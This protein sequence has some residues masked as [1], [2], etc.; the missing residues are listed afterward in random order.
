MPGSSSGLE[1]TGRGV[2]HL[3]CGTPPM[4]TGFGAVMLGVRPVSTGRL[5]REVTRTTNT[6]LVGLTPPARPLLE[7]FDRRA[8][9]GVD[10][11]IVVQLRDLE[12]VHRVLVDLAE[13]QAP[14]Q[15]VHLAA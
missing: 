6:R 11:E 12:H 7:R 3:Q 2:G 8:L 15:L 10:F 14:A 9:I 1:A 4:G 13:P 5:S